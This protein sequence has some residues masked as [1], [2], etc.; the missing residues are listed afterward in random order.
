M[1]KKIIA[2]SL[3][4]IMI[5]V[6]FAACG[7]DKGYKLDVDND[8]FTHAYAT[9]AEGN[10]VLNDNGDIIVYQTEKNGEIARDAEGNKIENILEMPPVVLLKHG[11]ETKDFILN[12]DDSWTRGEDNKYIKNGDKAIYI[13]I[14]EKYV[15]QGDEKIDLDGTVQRDIDYN[16]SLLESMGDYA[17]YEYGYVEINGI[18]MHQQTFLLKGNDGNLINDST[19]YNFIIGKRLYEVSYYYYGLQTETKVKEPFDFSEYFRSIFTLK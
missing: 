17:K 2:V 14:K 16:N 15:C 4:I 6:F 3:V 19:V 13:E 1:N 10:T 18:K 7:K 11:C 5:T 8:G 12:F 9:D